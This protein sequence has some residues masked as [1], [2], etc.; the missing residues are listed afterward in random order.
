[1]RMKR[2]IAGLL[3]FILMIGNPLTVFANPE[4]TVSQNEILV[5]EVSSTV[6]ENE[7]LIETEGTVSG[8]SVEN[9]D[10]GTAEE[11]L[12][13][14]DMDVE[15]QSVEEIPYEYIE[16]TEEAQADLQ[17]DLDEKDIFALVYLTN[18]YA[19]KSEPRTEAPTVLSV[20][21]AK[22]VQIL[23]M[24]V[25]W[26][27]SLEW[28]EYIPNVWYETQFYEGETL[29]SGYI[30][31][32]YLA[33]S[34]EKLLQWKDSWFM[35]FPGSVSM[36]ATTDF[37]ADINL[38]PTSYRSA[39]RKLKDAHPNWTFVPMN[40][41]RSWDACVTEQAGTSN[42]DPYSWIYYNQPA[43]FRGDKIDSTWYRATRE[44]IEYY[45][46][47]RNF[48]NETYI[49]QFEQNSFNKSY[50]TTDALD[51]YFKGSF[52]EGVVPDDSEGRTYSEVFYEVGANRGTT[53]ISP[54]FLAAKVMLEQ[55]KNGSQLVSG[56][57]P[58]YENLYNFFN[59]KAS[60]TGTTAVVNGLTYARQQGWNTRYKS[61]AG[62]AESYGKSYILKGQDTLYL[63][64]FDLIKSRGYLFQYQQNIMAPSTDGKSVKSMYSSSGA[65]NS[66]FVFKI[67]VFNNMPNEYKFSLNKSEVE[68]V[69]G[70]AGKE[71][72]TL[73]VNCD[74][75]AVES[76]NVTF[77]SDNDKVA[78]V[79]PAGVIS[80]VGSGETTIHI[81]VIYDDMDAAETFECKVTVLSPLQDISLNLEKQ[82]L[83][84]G[85]NLPEKVAYL[86]ENGVTQYTNEVPA[87]VTLNVSYN[88]IDTTDSR[89]VTW[90]VENED[91]VSIEKR[92]ENGES[93]VVTA[94][95][96]G[97]TTV[98]ATVGGITKT[99]EI[100]VRI[101]MTQAA[102]KQNELTLYKGQTTQIPATY[103]PYNTSDRVEVVWT[104]EDEN[105]AEV[106]S[107]GKIMAKG[108]GTT[109]LHAAIGPFDGSQSELTVEVTVE[110]YTV[111][112]M[113]ADGTNLLSTTGEY[114]KSLEKL[115]SDD[116]EEIP[117]TIEKEDYYF[118]GWYTGEN[119][120]GN[121]V[122][123]NT[124]LYAD[125]VLYPYF[126]SVESTELYVKPIGSVIYTGAYIKPDVKVY[127]ADVLL[128]KGVDYTLT[129]QNNK[130]VNDGSNPEKMPTVV[131]K[132]KGQYAGWE[133]TQTFRIVA[134][135]LSH[136]DITAPDLSAD[137]TGNVQKLRPSVS[138]R[139]RAL[140]YNK[141]YKLEYV[142]AMDGA[143]KEA[144]TYTVKII[145]IGNYTGER[146]A[147]ITISKRVMMEDVTVS[148]VNEVKYNNG[149]PYTSDGELEACRPVVT[150]KYN[151]STLLE[152]T[153]YI[154]V[155]T[156]NKDI[157]TAS[158]TA[159]GQ[160][161][162]IG[163]RTLYFKIVGTQ[164]S[165]VTVSGIN[166]KE[167]TGE[168]IS[169]N[170]LVVTD[171]SKNVLQ[172][173][174]DYEITYKNNVKTGK[175]SVIFTGIHG[176]TGSV[177]K[178]FT[179]E[180]YDIA[181]NSLTYEEES[182]NGEDL[183][184][185]PAFEAELLA[186]EVEYDKA[187]VKPKVAVTFKGV[188][189][190]EGTDYKISYENNY[191]VA[192]ESAEKPPTVVITGKGFFTGSVIKT[193]IITEKDIAKVNMTAKDVK[194]R[195]RQGFCFVEPVLTDESGR[196]LK[197]GTD[198]ENQLIY[199]YATDVVLYDGTVRLAGEPVLETDIPTPG[200][201]KDGKITVTA[202]GVGNYTGKVSVTYAILEN[203]SWL[204]DVFGE[205]QEPK[206]KINRTVLYLNPI[207]PETADSIK[208][209]VENGTLLTDKT[210][211]VYKPT[212]S[213]SREELADVFD[214]ILEEGKLTLKLNKSREELADIL[215]DGNYVFSITPV[216]EIEGKEVTL[217]ERTVTVRIYRNEPVVDW[218]Q[219]GSID[220]LFRDTTA[221]D[222]T[223]SLES[224]VDSLIIPQNQSEMNAAYYLSGED[225]LNYRLVYEGSEFVDDYHANLRIQAVENSF[226]VD[227]SNTGSEQ[228][229]P[230]EISDLTVCCKTAM[231]LELSSKVHITLAQS[232]YKVTPNTYNCYVKQKDGKG[233]LIFSST[234]P[235][236]YDRVSCSDENVSVTVSG[237]TLFFE[238]IEAE[239]YQDGMEIP[240]TVSMYAKGAG[241]GTLPQNFDVIL[242]ICDDTKLE[243]LL[244]IGDAEE[245]TLEERQKLMTS[246]EETKR[247]SLYNRNIIRANN[248][249]FSGVSIAFL[250]DSITAGVG[251]EK[252]GIEPNVYTSVVERSLN[253]KE[254]YRFG[255]GGYAIGRH[256]PSVSL[257]SMY[258]NVPADTDIIF[259]QGGIN[260]VYSGSEATFGSLSALSQTGTFCAD[261]YALMSALQADYPDAQIIFLTPLSTI[262]SEWYKEMLPN[263]LEVS[264]YAS[265]M[266]A[267]A[268]KEELPNVEV[269]DL[270]NANILDSFDEDIRA[271]YMY[272]G[273]HPGIA[274]HRV[275]GEYIASRLIRQRSG[276]TAIKPEEVPDVEYVTPLD[277]LDENATDHTAAFNEAIKE[278]HNSNKAV[279]VPEGT[280]R[281]NADIGIKV[282]SGVDIIMSPNA[283]IKALG[284]AINHSRVFELYLADD[285][286]ITGGQIIGERYHHI[287]TSGEW[288][289]GIRI[290][291]CE[292]VTISDV[293]ISN[294]WG[295]GIYIGAEDE[296]VK[297]AG[298][299]NITIDN[300]YLYNNRRNNLSIVCGRDITVKHCTF[301]NAHGTAPGYGIDIEPNYPHIN[302]SQRI[303]IHDCVFSENEGGSMAIIT[304]SDD[305]TISD[306]EMDGMF[307]NYAG[308]NVKIL[309]TRINNEMY[310]RY[311]VTIDEKSVINDG[312]AKEDVLVASLSVDKD[313]YTFI[314]YQIDGNSPMTAEIIADDKSLSGKAVRLK[315]TAEGNKESGYYLKVSEF[316]IPEGFSAALEAGERYRFEYVMKGSGFWGIKT[317]QTAWYPCMLT[318][319]YRTGFTTYKAKSASSCNL[320]LYACDKTKDMHME[321]SSIKIYKIQ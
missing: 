52:M 290:Y 301:E 198:Y 236:T 8:N 35:L 60:G 138:D 114:G 248:V 107:S 249:D 165:T 36:Y 311:G 74:G 194:F 4:S 97:T 20:P 164:I 128:V 183:D 24:D 241:K 148:V 186:K 156:N 244:S 137:Y 226:Y 155:Y 190:K 54:F 48:L 133:T 14:P 315:R 98:S 118:I 111:T 110:E 82:D 139:G 70:T 119:G 59:I 123:Q 104:S 92:G 207:Y 209:G 124:I 238:L 179:I 259:V 11:I 99:V 115:V 68:L 93:A 113:N 246:Y 308:T 242:L 94:K 283:V 292:N 170:D 120:S 162:Y 174:L 135:S 321:V 187:G 127:N 298:C 140:Q 150:V 317:N 39:L 116:E 223:I 141:D 176:Y 26:Q 17:G 239:S 193:F 188:A 221:V 182:G 276:Y 152:N 237:R 247:M 147:Y 278:A 280:Y 10:N 163:S 208:L 125:M 254:V 45:M 281:I 84:I 23:G 167:Y 159:V 318:E 279:F 79:S 3:S 62:G 28:E 211:V 121:L 184:T 12:P 50:H 112:F 189:L 130:A 234:Q 314:D 262:T 295:D 43:N 206:L 136:V 13:L 91:I 277:Y 275:L 306:C 58:G 63:Q 161:A 196:R 192:S 177:T 232:E 76:G 146:Y 73:I 132:G 260:D 282:K 85:E 103:A 61:I 257:Y 131:I 34:D 180:P 87:Q 287:G 71:S 29:Y 175:A 129:Y 185:K 309:N 5:E 19:V 41:N 200:E 7:I 9:S 106:D 191:G 313:S 96:N 233:K 203:T 15:Q 252:V 256:D 271:E 31:D 240:V 245:M 261:T 89:K 69:R 49:F 1:M 268:E 319:E 197:A 264:R 75:S 51:L 168:A 153:D 126:V 215:P 229:A 37:Y 108:A 32:S 42:G 286:T 86:D 72:Y 267:I 195:N 90:T 210:T 265:A 269:W 199:T 145:G 157:G 16:I 67:P 21:S 181:K 22:T 178:T 18:S 166:D 220:L 272:D 288:G 218:Q 40:V 250:G 204:E 300:C 217:A 212:D 310:A 46:D 291:D 294:C 102:L 66:A 149:K 320:L 95:N 134:K 117:W 293:T 143:Y 80:A 270:Y 227:E 154:L 235:V 225:A 77:T 122:T 274:G 219:N 30:E 65:L 2:I 169:Q 47:P 83:F 151:G 263:M 305:I 172:E 78:T 222:V 55:G 299:D 64:K 296:D 88:P 230:G 144:G 316:D 202:K 304:S 297:G 57:Y 101:P 33:Y 289:M 302:Q 25:E 228:L 6:S 307:V 53:G 266:K 255:Y 251:L 258:T 100:N 173:G 224:D 105:V 38:F 160:G 201:L 303:L 231:G 142:D 44:A 216:A 205:T 284:S 243:Y 171:K 213:N 214:V 56:T 312:T 253:V 158:V 273:V 285:V 109:K 27:Y 81:S